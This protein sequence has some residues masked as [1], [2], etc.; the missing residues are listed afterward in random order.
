MKRLTLD[1]I[2]N[3]IDKKYEI[4]ETSN[5]PLYRFWEKDINERPEWVLSEL[6][7]ILI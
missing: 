3:R 7:K 6:K 2:K 1:I 4:C 5:I